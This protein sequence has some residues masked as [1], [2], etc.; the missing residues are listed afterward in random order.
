M[1]AVL[2]LLLGSPIMGAETFVANSVTYHAYSDTIHIDDETIV[3]VSAFSQDK[4]SDTKAFL[5]R[6]SFDW[7]DVSLKYQLVQ[8]S[9]ARKGIDFVLIGRDGCYQAGAT[10]M[11]SFCPDNDITG[12]IDT[13]GFS[14]DDLNDVTVEKTRLVTRLQKLIN[15]LEASR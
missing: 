15:S 4:V 6:R 8:L 3:R 9:S 13:K 12:T 10:Y 5:N 7:S 2:I 1:L 11:W 14:T